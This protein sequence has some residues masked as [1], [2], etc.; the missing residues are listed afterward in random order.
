MADRWTWNFDVYDESDSPTEEG[1]Y[2]II[3]DEGYEMTD[4]FFG[5]PRMTPHGIGY[6]RDG[7]RPIIAWKKAEQTEP[8]KSCSTCGYSPMSASCDTCEG[9]SNWWA[10]EQTEPCDECVFVKGSGWCDNCNGK[11]K[12]LDALPNSRK[13]E[14]TE[15]SS[16][17][18]PN[19]CD[20]CKHNKLEWYSE[21]CDGC[22]KAH[23]NYEPQTERSE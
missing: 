19:N 11:P 23:S 7:T 1:Y 14:Q 20:T 6:W 9:Y 10:L 21:V 5:E 22:S 18:K 4:Y 15:P 16:S 17:E 12:G 3:D 13:A 2:R 8:Q